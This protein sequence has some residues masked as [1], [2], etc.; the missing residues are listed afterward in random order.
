MFDAIIGMA[1]ISGTRQEKSLVQSLGVHQFS[2]C[3]GRASKSPGYLV[4]NDRDPEKL[5]DLF[6]PVPLVG[7]RHWSAT[8][9]Q[10]QL[11]HEGT[12]TES[13]GVVLDSGTTGIGAPLDF[14]ERVGAL[15]Q[16]V[17]DACANLEKLPPLKFKLGDVDYQLPP[18]A[19]VTKADSNLAPVLQSMAGASCIP[20]MVPLQDVTEYGP[21]WIL[22]MPFFR[23][24]YTTFQVDG[25]HRAAYTAPA[26]DGCEAAAAKRRPSL[27][28]AKQSALTVDMSKARLP[29]WVPNNGSKLML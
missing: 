13:C 15:L 25:A 17:D 22:G 2:L 26:S 14:I 9:H 4:W 5:P 10:V 28:L 27:L 21:L 6:T 1:G 8:L 3:F 11:G 18:S 12:C 16:D 20:L 7:N 23:H 19:Y 24:Y 29:L